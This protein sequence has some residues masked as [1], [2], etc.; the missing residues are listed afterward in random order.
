MPALDEIPVGNEWHCVCVDRQNLLFEFI[1]FLVKRTMDDSEGMRMKRL[2]IDFL[3]YY[4]PEP[5][6]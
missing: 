1:D 4:D 5:K 2:A 6:I 3:V